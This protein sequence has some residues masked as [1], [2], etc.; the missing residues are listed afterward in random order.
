MF[1][2]VGNR[3][4]SILYISTISKVEEDNNY[5]VEYKLGNGVKLYDEFDNSS[6]RDAKYNEIFEYLLG[7]GPFITVNDVLRNV[8]FFTSIQVEDNK[9]KYYNVPGN[10]I[11]E[12]FSSQADLE[13]K[14]KEIKDTYIGA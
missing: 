6:D 11:E 9:L 12:S 2:N 14:L 13:D 10:Y 3:L 5:K 4:V 7:C 1:I 8:M